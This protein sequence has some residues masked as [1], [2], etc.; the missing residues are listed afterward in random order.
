MDADIP[1]VLPNPIETPTTEQTFT[2]PPPAQ[3]YDTE[4]PPQYDN[5]NPATA[6]VGTETTPNEDASFTDILKSG[7]SKAAQG[8]KEAFKKGTDVTMQG[9]NY[10]KENLGPKLQDIGDKINPV[11]ESFSDNVGKPIVE[12]SQVVAN[13]FKET[14]GLQ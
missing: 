6:N 12:Y 10:L 8:T 2:P 9:V 11:M 13:K 4:V 5:P 7:A 1:P 3:P 14:F